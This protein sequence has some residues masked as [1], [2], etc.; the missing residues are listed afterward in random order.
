MED[1][2]FRMNAKTFRVLINGFVK[3]VRVDKALLFAKMWSSGF[4]VDVSLFYVL[5]GGL[6]KNKELEK[7]F[8]LY[9]EMKGLGIRPDAGVLAKLVSCCSSEGEMI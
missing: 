6:C 9:E 8:C 5:I 1:R 4:S 2:N 3:A 7:A